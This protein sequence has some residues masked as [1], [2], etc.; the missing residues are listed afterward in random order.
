MMVFSCEQSRPILAILSKERPFCK[1][2]GSPLNQWKARES[3]LRSR[4]QGGQINQG[5]PTGA[6]ALHHQ[7]H[8]NDL[9]LQDSFCAS[10]VM[11]SKAWEQMSDRLNR[12]RHYHKV[13][14]GIT[15]S[16]YF[17]FMCRN[18][19]EGEWALGIATL[20]RLTTMLNSP[21]RVIQRLKGTEGGVEC[22]PSAIDCKK[23]NNNKIQSKHVPHSIAYHA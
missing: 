8:K 18:R 1:D 4:I 20:Q 11:G 19:G 7:S 13:S 6:V 22:C 2:L 3:C 17:L 10:I 23:K 9:D 12:P 14:W 16:P 21:K 15:R 5:H